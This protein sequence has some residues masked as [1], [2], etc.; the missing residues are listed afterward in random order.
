M[1]CPVAIAICF[2]FPKMLKSPFWA[3]EMLV[4]IVILINIWRAKVQESIGCIRESMV[5]ILMM[6]IIMGGSPVIKMAVPEVNEPPSPY[7]QSYLLAI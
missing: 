4:G 3:L 6:I 1:I 5:T 2:A 7:V